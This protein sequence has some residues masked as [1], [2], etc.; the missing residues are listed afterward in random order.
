MTKFI[1]LIRKINSV[2]EN[3]ISYFYNKY[4]KTILHEI[5]EMSK[6]R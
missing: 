3:Y 6:K 1:I 2:I 4:K 5:L